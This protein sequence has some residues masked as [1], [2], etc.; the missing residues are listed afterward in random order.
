MPRDVGLVTPMVVV[1]G[2]IVVVVI[3]IVWDG[4]MVDEYMYKETGGI[5]SVIEW[6]SV[7][8][9]DDAVSVMTFVAVPRRTQSPAKNSKFFGQSMRTH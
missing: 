2:L 6:S 4:T 9:S 3:F 5:G 7:I 8:K 1:F